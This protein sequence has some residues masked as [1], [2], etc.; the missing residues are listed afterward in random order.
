[1]KNRDRPLEAK[2]WEYRGDYEEV[3]EESNPEGDVPRA[4][5]K[6]TLRMTEGALLEIKGAHSF[7]PNEFDTRR[8]RDTDRERG[9]EK[10]D[11]MMRKGKLS[12]SEHG[13]SPLSDISS[14]RALGKSFQFQVRAGKLVCA[15]LAQSLCD[16]IFVGALWFGN[17]PY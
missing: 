16:H 17:S 8:F 9:R 3:H 1:M 6:G 2:D 12:N 7:R 11:D 15:C 4:G 14:R 13:N 5:S 10:N